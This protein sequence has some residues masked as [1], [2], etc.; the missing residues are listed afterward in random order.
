MTK[1][2]LIDEILTMNKTAK[3][4]FLARFA[5]DDLE[6]YLRQLLGLNKPVLTGNAG[7]YEKYFVYRPSQAKPIEVPVIE[8]L[9]QVTVTVAQEA[10]LISRAM[11]DQPQAA[12]AE[13]AQQQ[14]AEVN[15]AVREQQR[16][17]RRSRILTSRL[18]RICPPMVHAEA[19]SPQ[20]AADDEEP[21]DS[22][23][24]G[25]YQYTYTG[26]DTWEQDEQGTE[27][28][29]SHLAAEESHTAQPREP[30]IDEHREQPD[31][32]SAEQQV[33]EEHSVA[34]QPVG[35]SISGNAQ[36]SDKENSD[37]WLF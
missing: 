8:P 25:G 17:Y 24:S 23:V 20:A 21:A 14:A 22:V 1:R 27:A 6:E 30:V 5:Q 4:A 37:S 33:I 2:Q 9:P 35:A 36:P 34:Q 19:E 32:Q 7:R 3:P 12:P 18:S 26:D 11:F 28:E 29:D 31:A 16:A 10:E 15:A 13:P